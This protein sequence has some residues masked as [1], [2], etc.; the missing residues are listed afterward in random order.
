[1][2]LPRRISASDGGRC[3]AAGGAALRLGASLSIADGADHRAVRARVPVRH[4]RAAYGSMA[5]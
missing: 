3:R 1:M 5:I 4:P 2:K